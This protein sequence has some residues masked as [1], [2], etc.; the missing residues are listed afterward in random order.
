MVSCPWCSH[1]ME[2]DCVSDVLEKYAV[3]ILG[4]CRRGL[5]R[6]VAGS[7]PLRNVRNTNAQNKINIMV[8]VQ[9]T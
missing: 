2:I 4:K 7:T 8:S 6:V 9:R 5:I 3:A 1:H